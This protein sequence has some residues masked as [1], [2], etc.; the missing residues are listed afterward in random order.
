[1]EKISIII[2]NFNG[3]HF[4]EKS[5]PS[6][7]KSSYSNFELIICDDA[8]TDQSIQYLTQIQN[9]DNRIILL[10][11]Q[12]NLGAAA[13]R[14]HAVSIAT[15]ET[16][17][18]IDNDTEV[19]SNWIEPMTVLLQNDQSLGAIQSTLV[20]YHDH[21]IIQQIGVHLIPHAFW[22]VPLGQGESLDSRSKK[23]QEIIAISAAMA[24]RKKVYTQIHGFD[25]L[26]GVYTEDLEFSFRIWIS[27]FKIV[28]CPESIVYHWNK[29]VEDR[30]IM[31]G[32]KRNIYFHLAKNSIRS[33]IK[34]YQL[35]NLIYY[36][37]FT[38]SILS[39][40]VL[41]QLVKGQTES[42]IGTTKAVIWTILNLK[43]TLNERKFVQQELRKS[44]DKYIMDKVFTKK[45]LLSIYKQYFLKQ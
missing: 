24:V 33:I 2:A 14:N 40:R 42:F 22:G 36:L 18:L 12:K 25:Q 6:I 41:L 34:N 13:T 30:Q 9:Q 43:D 45:S 8:S 23:S 35:R 27:G 3:Q 21:K 7:L 5:I 10:K 16:L 32:T 26:L 39:A 1:M 17:I 20:D 11:N 44:S 19:Q 29:K 28:S 4:L 38:C 31:H 15:T 37:P